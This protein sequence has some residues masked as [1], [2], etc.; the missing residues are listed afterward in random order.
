M[1][2]AP[3]LL[4]A[5]LLALPMALAMALVGP[6]AL[7]VG[8]DDTMT[9]HIAMAP[10]AELPARVGEAV[11]Q[12]PDEAADIACDIVALRTEAAV[13]VAEA[14]ARAAPGA[15]ADIAFCATGIA[16]ER[17]AAIAAAIAAAVPARSEAVVEAACMAAPEAAGEIAEAVSRA[18]PDRANA[19]RAAAEAA[20]ARLAPATAGAEPPDEEAP[21]QPTP[22]PSAVP[23]GRGESGPGPPIDARPAVRH[24]GGK[25][26][27][28]GRAEEPGY[29]LY[30]YLLFRRGD[31]A[32]IALERRKAV[33][34]AFV[35]EVSPA[36]SLEGAGVARRE[37]NVLYAPVKAP[38]GAAPQGQDAVYEYLLAH[39]DIDRSR[40]LLDRIG[41]PEDGPYLVSNLTP[42]GSGAPADRDR[43]LVQ[44]LSRVPPRLAGLWMTEF[45]RQA[46]RQDF[47]D[48][49]NL[50]R[51]AL[52]LRT[53]IANLSEAFAITRE[54]VAGMIEP[55]K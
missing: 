14:A 25:L 2:R 41:L 30:S 55:P 9:G 12:V 7:A 13:A 34:R 29:G 47:W 37:I 24:T 54:A 11:R 19:I 53:E 23:D 45:Q 4:A 51:F 5:S 50:R 32:G 43:M 20:L 15:A 35:E 48:G 49:G 27:F 40:L 1:R 8:L 10:S 21:P 16:P 36:A 44:D 31:S 46:A 26:L 52:L 18:L 17:A 38:A 28:S 3:S 33:L 39:Y 42:V 22:A 6:A